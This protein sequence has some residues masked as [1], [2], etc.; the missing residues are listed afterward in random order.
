MTDPRSHAHEMSAAFGR[1]GS[2]TG[3]IPQFLESPAPRHSVLGF[4]DFYDTA[5]IVAAFTA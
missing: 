5:A 1:G 4:H 3:S 2:S